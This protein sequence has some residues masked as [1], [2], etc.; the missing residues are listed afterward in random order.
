MCGFAVAGRVQIL[1]PVDRLPVERLGRDLVGGKLLAYPLQVA[2]PGCD[3]PI[4]SLVDPCLEQRFRKTFL[5]F[6]GV[7]VDEVSE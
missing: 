4:A 2:Y 6:L 7:F 1:F 3:I 5:P